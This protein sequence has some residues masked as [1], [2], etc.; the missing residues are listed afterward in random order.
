MGK[1]VVSE[2]VSLD[3]VIQDPTGEEDLGRCDWRAHVGDKDRDAWAA[4]L[5]AEALAPY[6]A[7]CVV[8]VA[9]TQ[10][11]PVTGTGRAGSGLRPS[12]WRDAPIGRTAKS[13]SAG[14]VSRRGG[15]CRRASF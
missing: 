9:A 15:W 2:N 13:R 4:A 5:F 8:G 10:W 3:G 14:R 11:S 1:I 12:R 6:P 7:V